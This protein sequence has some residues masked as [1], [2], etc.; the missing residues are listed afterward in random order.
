MIRYLDRTFIAGREIMKSICDFSS[1]A[2]TSHASKK[3]EKDFGP[4]DK[5]YY[6]PLPEAGFSGSIT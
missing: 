2:A 6:P 5:N 1:E 3:G 4:V